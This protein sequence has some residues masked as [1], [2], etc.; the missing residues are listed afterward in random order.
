[1]Q[2]PE[3]RREHGTEGALR[4]PAAVL[5]LA[6]AWTLVAGGPEPLRAQQA[7]QTQ[8]AEY[9]V[10]KGDTL[11]DI[12]NRLLDDPFQWQ[13][14]WKAN[15]S[16]IDN[17]D[18]IFPGERFAIPGMEGEAAA[19]RDRARQQAGQEEA[20][21]RMRERMKER[22]AEAEQEAGVVVGGAGGADT[23]APARAS[24]FETGRQGEGIA[25]G[26]FSAEE[27]PP[28]RPVSRTGVWG[29]PFIAGREVLRPR[30]R[31]LG[32]AT[33]GDRP[34]EA[35][36]GRAGDEV[37]VA[38]RGLSASAGDTLFAVELGRSLGERGR[39]VQPTAMLSLETVGADTA[40]ARVHGV[41]G[42][43][44]DGDPVVLYPVPPVP[45]ATEFREADGELTARILEAADG[46]ALLREGGLVFLDSGSADGVRIGDLF[47]AAPPEASAASAGRNGVRVIVVR[48]RSGSSTA[49]VVFPGDGTVSQ[50]ATARLVR[51]L[52]VPGR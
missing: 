39:V 26:G 25:S 41:F 9:E 12:A 1:M 37:R 48:V 34:V 5:L 28:L 44:R 23:A 20:E 27:R 42:L 3:R 40:L 24:L 45:E 11:W 49:R 13:R 18:L 16:A 32:P 35:W 19:A 29:A 30:G 6:G 31:V 7:G 51:R 2:T 33:A 46:S 10:E 8:Q 52:A 15:Q 36:Q 22:R 50:G 21:E 17:P 43:V 4:I 38:L 14:I 47:L